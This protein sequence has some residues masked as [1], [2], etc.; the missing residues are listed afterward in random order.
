[1]LEDY[2]LH[3]CLSAL[4]YSV[5]NRKRCG[6]RNETNSGPSQLF[7]QHPVD[8]CSM[9]KKNVNQAKMN[10]RV[11]S[12]TFINCD[13][14]FTYS[15]VSTCLITKQDIKCSHTV[16]ATATYHL[17]QQFTRV[18]KKKI[19]FMFWTKVSWF[20]GHNVPVYLLFYFC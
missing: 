7:I 4:L 15:H 20:P 6:S 3:V 10:E 17:R 12:K 18:V 9:G 11:F 13:S 16:N 2:M 8:Y 19:V 14:I 1:M 5:E